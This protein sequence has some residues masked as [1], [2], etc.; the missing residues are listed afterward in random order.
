MTFIIYLGIE[1]KA[2]IEESRQH[3]AAMLGA[4]ASGNDLYHINQTNKFI[5]S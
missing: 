3:V 5:P 1:A 4:K 2:I